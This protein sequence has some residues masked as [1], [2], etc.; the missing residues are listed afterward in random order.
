MCKKKKDNHLIISVARLV[1]DKGETVTIF[2]Y[3]LPK[4]PGRFF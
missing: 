4:W 1:L 2:I 3:L